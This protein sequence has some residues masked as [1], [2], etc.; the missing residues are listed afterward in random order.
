MLITIESPHAHW[1]LGKV[2]KV[3]PGKD[4]HVRSV[5]SQVGDKQLVRPIVKLCPLELEK[6]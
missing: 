1:L 2:V 3:Y 4:G 6:I 5:K